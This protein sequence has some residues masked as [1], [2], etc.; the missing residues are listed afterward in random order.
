MNT[1][2]VVLAVAVA[3]LVTACDQRSTGSAVAV[4]R[5]AQEGEGTV[6]SWIVEDSEN[7]IVIDAQRSLS[8]GRD[9]A[10][11]IETRGKP[12]RAIL[13]THPHPD[14]FGGID[15]ILE[16]FPSTP[17]LS[18]P[19]TQRIMQNDENGFIALTKQVL[20]SDAPEKQTI[21][22]VTFEDGQELKWGEITL[23]AD[24]RGVGE[25]DSMSIFLEPDEG[26]LFVGDVVDNG[27]TSFMMEGHT[28]QWLLQL[29][30]IRTDYAAE[31]L[32]VFPGHGP[33]GDTSLFQE[34]IDILTWVRGAV[35]DRL[36]D[37]LNEREIDEIVELYEAA[38]PDRPAVAAVPNLMH[39]NIRA[40]AKELS[41][42]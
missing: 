42:N 2:H 25:A 10:D 6:N 12:L 9:L 24:E 15:A 29:R 18:S 8:A 37:G 3:L 30:N 13:I 41:T 33:R 32:V 4:S 22:T 27:M 26:F 11:D 36:N 5:F 28:G 23:I 34:G 20:G 14:H 21:P 35:G 17:I 1:L 7:L 31:D 39:E 40:V 19:L 16:R 38:Y